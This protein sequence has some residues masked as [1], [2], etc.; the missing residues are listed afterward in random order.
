MKKV[1]KKEDKVRIIIFLCLRILVLLCMSYQI[2]E[3]NWDNV[4]S[5]VLVLATFF[6][7][8]F[9]DKKFSIKLPNVLEIVLVSF[10][11]SAIILGEINEFYLKIPFFDT[12]LHTI[13]GFVMGGVGFS[14]INILNNNNETFFLLS[15]KY[16]IIAS[17]CFSMTIGVLWEFIEYGSDRLLNTDMQ[18]DTIIR[19]IVSVKFN[20][21]G[22]NIPAKKE[23]DSI[24]INDE[25]WNEI[26]GGYIDVGLYDTMED[27]IVNFIGSLLF[28]LFGYLYLKYQ[29]P[30][31]K[32]FIPSFREN[33]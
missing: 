20:E 16:V 6:I 30:F 21:E 2:I 8:V 22:K 27:L 7:P 11:F 10:V 23:I 9:I 1:F 18:K 17:I 15:T 25:D 33:K 29:K 4:F 32:N 12:L 28:A 26:Y 5:C 24:I 31:A 3:K 19:E 14:I 13:N